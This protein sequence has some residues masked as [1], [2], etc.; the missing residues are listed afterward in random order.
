MH[1]NHLAVSVLLTALLAGCANQLQDVNDSLKKVNDAL[2]GASS[3]PVGALGDGSGYQPNFNVSVPG[4][5]CNR[6]AY[7]DGF[8]DSYLVQWN[9]FVDGKQTMYRTMAK[10]DQRNAPAKQN[11]DLYKSRQ[12]GAMRYMGHQADY[13]PDFT[14]NNCAYRSYVAGQTAGLDAVNRDSRALV[15]QELASQPASR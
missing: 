7:L 14:A 9:Q 3:V 11:A 2:S 12:I 10:Q 5:V 8:K 1:K 6:Q 4:T 13:P 15:A